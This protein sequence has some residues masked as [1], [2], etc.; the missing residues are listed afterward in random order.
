M[1]FARLVA[2][3]PLDALVPIFDK[4]R[5]DSH[6]RDGYSK[7]AYFEAEDGGA[8]ADPAHIVGGREEATSIP[9]V[10]IDP[11]GSR[12]LDQAVHIERLGDGH[13]VFYAI[14]DVAAHVTPGGALDLDTRQRVETIYSPDR[15]IGLHPPV[16]S[17]GYASLL[18]G[19]RT[20]SVLWTLDLDASGDLVATSL[21]RVWATSRA[22]YSYAQLAS[23][24]PSEAVELVTLMREVGKRR[25]ALTKARG[26]VTLPKPSQEVVAIDGHLTI[27]F[28]ASRGIDDDNAQISL[29]TGEA[30]ARLM[31]DAGVGILRTMPPAT[32]GSLRRLRRQAK[33]LGI[34]WPADA[35]Y[36]DLL[37]TFDLDAPASAAFLVEAVS[38]FRGA[39]WEAFNDSDPNLTRSDSITH[40]A[41]AVAYAHVTAPLRRLAD[42]YA[43]EICLAHAHGE[44][45]P[46][47]VIEALPWIGDEMARGVRV[48]KRVDRA[49]IDAVEAAMLAPHV[50]ETFTGIGLD[51][52]TVQLRTPAV[53]ARCEG[54]VKPGE[55]QDIRLVS[56]RPEHGMLFTV[57][58]GK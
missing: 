56:S 11:V 40:G 53:V 5:K 17:E 35:S 18:P 16:L 32:K 52:S 10:T 42:R 41:L 27:E 13:R 29:L 31:L 54:K 37:N 1:P 58:T 38:L 6:V 12:D 14:A 55:E 43:T 19:Q 9:L 28:R 51:D 44:A 26:A 45:V 24:P 23:A 49:C 46:A 21:R 36:A 50:G 2:R 30:A 22:Q 47:W 7:D 48:A 20:K 34:D 3:T 57:V 39:S 33:G 8:V 15:R 25:R 4:I